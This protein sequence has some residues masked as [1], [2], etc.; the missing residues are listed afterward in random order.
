MILMRTNANVNAI[1]YI[2]Q[3]NLK[4]GNKICEIVL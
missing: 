4:D 2:S 3:R 1:K